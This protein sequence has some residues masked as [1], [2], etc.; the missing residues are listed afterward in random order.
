MKIVFGSREADVK[1]LA[2]HLRRYAKYEDIEDEK[3]SFG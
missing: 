3:Y 2:D 1:I